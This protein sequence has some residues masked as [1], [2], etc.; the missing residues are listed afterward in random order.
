MRRLGAGAEGQHRDCIRWLRGVCY[1]PALASGHVPKGKPHS[2]AAV[3]HEAVGIRILYP[4]LAAP[5]LRQGTK[6]AHLSGRGDARM[7]RR[8]TLLAAA[9]ALTGGPASA[10]A[11]PWKP[12]RPVT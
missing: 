8:R 7:M 12:S 1:C 9:A 2:L 11:G 6:Q 10:Q 5:V 3:R 4:R